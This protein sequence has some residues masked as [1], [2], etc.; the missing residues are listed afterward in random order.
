MPP[1][2]GGDWAGA[3]AGVVPFLPFVPFG[4]FG[5]LADATII[6]F[7]FKRLIYFYI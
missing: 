3:G 4:L 1:F 6:Q 7:K 2:F 5:G